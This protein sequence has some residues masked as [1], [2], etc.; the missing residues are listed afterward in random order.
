MSHFS[1]SLNNGVISRRLLIIASVASFLIPSRRRAHE[2]DLRAVARELGGD[3][4]A[5]AGAPARDQRR[6]A[7]QQVRGRNGDSISRSGLRRRRGW[8]T[9]EDDG[10]VAGTTGWPLHWTRQNVLIRGRQ[11]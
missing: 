1:P 6:L 8:E 4:E 7:P 11:I 3:L 2:G 9:V 10:V 5:D